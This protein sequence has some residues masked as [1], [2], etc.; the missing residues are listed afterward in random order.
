[1]SDCQTAHTLVS[2]YA[3][4]NLDKTGLPSEKYGQIYATKMDEYITEACDH[5]CGFYPCTP[6]DSDISD[7][8]NRFPAAIY[9][10][11]FDAA[12][13]FAG[14]GGATQQAV[15]ETVN[16]E[17]VMASTTLWPCL[18]GVQFIPDPM[19]SMNIYAINN[20]NYATCASYWSDQFSTPVNNTC[21]PTR[22]VFN[23]VTQQNETVDM[24]PYKSSCEN[25]ITDFCSTSRTQL[26]N[27]AQDS[28]NG[29]NMPQEYLPLFQAKVDEYVDQA[30]RHQC[31]AESCTV[32]TS[33]MRAWA[34]SF[35]AML[36]Y[37]SF[38]NTGKIYQTVNTS[39]SDMNASRA[40]WSSFSGG[41]DYPCLPA[42]QLRLDPLKED[43]TYSLVNP[44]L[45]S[46]NATLEQRYSQP[47]N[48]ACPPTRS[49]TNW[50]TKQVDQVNMTPYMEDCLANVTPDGDTD[51]YDQPLDNGSCPQ[52]RCISDG[53][54]G[55]VKAEMSSIQL[56]KCKSSE[57]YD[58]AHDDD[59]LPCDKDVDPIDG[60]GGGIPTWVWIVAGFGAVAL[61]AGVG[62]YAYYRSKKHM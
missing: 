29:N 11:K 54:G 1:M 26:E 49:E 30:C 2:K 24:T 53:K 12:G 35:P 38:D 48:N 16:T 46:C 4:R 43:P 13:K 27:L 6:A 57:Y 50:Q 59:E 62:G 14:D 10:P 32:N 33:Q 40:Y 39:E 3:K 58:P 55:H 37:P 25:T 15:D 18:Q 19:K 34:S 45:E 20:S 9:Y 42:L 41:T 31:N 60:G 28:L 36:Y 21:P 7:W 8:A 56:E 23:T 52:F 61:A 17:K 22:K 51:P 5:S 44:S 47:V